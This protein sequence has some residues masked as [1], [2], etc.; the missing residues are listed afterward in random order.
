[1]KRKTRRKFQWIVFVIVYAIFAKIMFGLYQDHKNINSPYYFPDP[2]FRSLVL[3]HLHIEPGGKLSAAIAAQWQTKLD[4]SGLGI[5][6]L[7]GIEFFRN[8]NILDCSRNEI[9]E[10]D[11]SRN[12]SLLHLICSE[13]QLTELDV[14]N[15]PELTRLSFDDNSIRSIDVGGCIWLKQLTCS[16]NQLTLLDCSSSCEMES[17]VCSRNQIT[18]LR[19]PPSLRFRTL[20]CSQNQLT[21][22]DC[23]QIPNLSEL[24]ASQNLLSQINLRRNAEL[25]VLN[26]SHNLFQSIPELSNLLNLKTLDIRM[27]FLNEDDLSRLDDLRQKISPEIQEENPLLPGAVVRE[28]RAEFA[29]L[30]QRSAAFPSDP[31]PQ[32]PH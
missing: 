6:S 12:E 27:N 24:N 20:D 8:L 16:N 21:E 1:M 9:R 30:P 14:S 2:Q 22:L 19:L 17:I 32:N 15:L 10:L 18:E 23:S 13:N 31:N 29:F 26:L 28:G 3:R 11:F 7:Q 25:S 5:R 4:C